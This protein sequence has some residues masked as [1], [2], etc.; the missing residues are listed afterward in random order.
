M[1]P[2]TRPCRRPSEAVYTYRSPPAAQIV[3][4]RAYQEPTRGN[5]RRPVPEVGGATSTK[6]REIHGTASREDP[7]PAQRNAVECHSFQWW[8]AS[9]PTS[10][11]PPSHYDMLRPVVVTSLISKHHN[12]GLV[13]SKE[14]I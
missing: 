8:R 11:V 10:P 7:A 13:D 2:T 5:R 14:S 9:S 3:R 12:F 4:I 6:T 1:H